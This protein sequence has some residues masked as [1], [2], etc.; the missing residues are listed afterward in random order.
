[1]Q[2]NP[3]C[4][5][6]LKGV[7]QEMSNCYCHPGIAGGTLTSFS[8]H[9]VSRRAF[10]GARRPGDQAVALKRA[11]SSEPFVALPSLYECAP[12]PASLPPCTTRYSLRIGRPSK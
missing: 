6:I 2:L 11:A 4:Q 7:L 5:H 9:E 1:M 10:Q 3:A 12:T 8:F